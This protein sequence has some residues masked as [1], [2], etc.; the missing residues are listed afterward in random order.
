MRVTQ[1]H[2]PES[3]AASTEHTDTLVSRCS[4][5]G[6]RLCFH[7]FFERSGNHIIHRL[8]GLYIIHSIHRQPASAQPG[9]AA[10]HRVSD[11]GDD[12]PYQSV[13]HGSSLSLPQN[14]AGLISHPDRAY[15]PF[16]PTGGHF[17]CRHRQSIVAA[18]AGPT[19]PAA[20]RH[21]SQSHRHAGKGR[22]STGI[23]FSRHSAPNF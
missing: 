13:Q 6:K 16:R 15:F 21:C 17:I 14:P 22:R 9:T 8:P 1:L 7:A 18:T 20:G 3:G 23:T 11:D 5:A 4:A 2:P 10:F 19:S 12:I